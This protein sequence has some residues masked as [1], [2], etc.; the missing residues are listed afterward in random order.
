MNTEQLLGLTVIELEHGTTIGRVER[1]LI[2][3]DEK[4]LVALEV[5]GKLA[6][7]A[8]YV[9]FDN[10]KSVEGDVLVIPSTQSLV[11]RRNLPDVGVTDHITGRRVYTDDGKDLGTLHGYTIDPHS[12]E[13]TS[14]TFAVDKGVLGGLWKK[15]GDTY[16]VP[17]SLVRTLGES[18]IVDSSVPDVT[19]M[20]KAA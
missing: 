11:D 5:N 2:H 4:R 15:A 6:S 3:Q 9:T 12:G 20:S 14:I 16:E 17:M 13:I 7:G 19:G 10:I 1:V 8:R 18:V